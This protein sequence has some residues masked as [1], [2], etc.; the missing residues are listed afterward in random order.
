M[1]RLNKY[2]NNIL[3]KQF[4]SHKNEECCGILVGVKIKRD[5]IVKKI[6]KSNNLHE[7]KKSHYLIDS[8]LIMTVD[9]ISRKNKLDVLGFYHS[10]VKNEPNFSENDYLFAQKEYV[11]LILG[12]IGGNY[13]KKAWKL[14]KDGKLNEIFVE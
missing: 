12:I 6:C 1:L 8:N 9:K 5:Y 11:Y 13:S 7:N 2:Q 14:N 3:R 10:H 4:K